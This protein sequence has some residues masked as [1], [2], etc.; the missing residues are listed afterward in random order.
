MKPI[1]A[2][3]VLLISAA[4][5]SAEIIELSASA[6]PHGVTIMRG[7]PQRCDGPGPVILKADAD[8]K[9]VRCASPAAKRHH[10]RHGDRIVIVVAE[11]IDDV[12]IRLD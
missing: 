12:Y 2:S 7:A 10:H 11:K 4:P 9:P 5:A 1:V 8:Q 6:R 3:L